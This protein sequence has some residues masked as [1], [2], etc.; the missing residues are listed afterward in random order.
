MISL[1]SSTV[2]KIL[3]RALNGEDISV[4]EAVTLL[5]VELPEEREA[6]RETSD[7]LRHRQDRKSVV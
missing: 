4:A 7:R 5:S 2:E 1:T 3:D 6:V